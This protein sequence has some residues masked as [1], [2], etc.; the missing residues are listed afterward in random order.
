MNQK[1]RFANGNARIN[2]WERKGERSTKEKGERSK[3]EAI[4]KRRGALKWEQE[5]RWIRSS[6]YKIKIAA[7]HNIYSTI[8][9]DELGEEERKLFDA[10]ANVAGLEYEL[11]IARYKLARLI[12]EH[13]RHGYHYGSTPAPKP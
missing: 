4:K 6:S 10:M 7:T 11:Q 1:T 2:G 13:G 5:R 9:R 12:R 3:P 8:I